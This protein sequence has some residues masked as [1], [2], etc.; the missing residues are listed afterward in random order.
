[1]ERTVAGRPTLDAIGDELRE[2]P[3]MRPP[4]RARLETLSY[5]QQPLESGARPPQGSAPEVITI[6]Q[7]PIGRA[8]QA[9]IEDALAEEVL[10]TTDASREATGKIPV[11]ALE[12][13][14]IF[15]VSTFVVQGAEI[16]SKAS[17]AARRAF[18][19]ERLLHRLPALS[20]DEVVRI[21]VTRGA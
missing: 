12:P 5:D 1:V 11:G 17:D 14:E 16:F 6:G 21:D 18:V 3:P 9:A 10:A 4:M 2:P 15:E 19:A 8:T 20:M 7:A 13:A